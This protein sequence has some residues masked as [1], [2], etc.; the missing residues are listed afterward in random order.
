MIAVLVSMEDKLICCNFKTGLYT[1]WLFYL[2][3]P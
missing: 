2:D 3:R 1:C